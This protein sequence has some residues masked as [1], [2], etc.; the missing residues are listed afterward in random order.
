MPPLARFY[1][2]NSPP[3]RHLLHT[4]RA[5]LFFLLVLCGCD[6]G[7]SLKSEPQ[8]DSSVNRTSVAY[9]L[10]QSFSLELDLNAHAGFSWYHTI[11]YPSVIHLD[12][13]SFRPK[14]G[15]WNICGGG[16]VE[17]FYFRTT[18]VGKCA[19]DLAERQGWLPN[20]PPINAVRFSVI[21]FR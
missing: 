1:D 8:L 10:D 11:S 14:N 7:D 13:T 18:R 3:M 5:F 6:L 4:I 16:T 2:S 21:V 15:N 12:S 19:I 17:T 20:D 9:T